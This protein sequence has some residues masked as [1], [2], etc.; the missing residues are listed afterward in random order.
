LVSYASA[1]YWHDYDSQN[2]AIARFTGS[3]GLQSWVGSGI[4]KAEPALLQSGGSQLI[5]FLPFGMAPVNFG[6][7]LPNS[8]F[9]TYSHATGWFH[10]EAWQLVGYNAS[11]LEHNIVEE[12]ISAES[13]STIKGLQ[14]AF[15]RNL[16]LNVNGLATTADVVQE[17]KLEFN[18]TTR[19]ITHE[20]DWYANASTPVSITIPAGARVIGA[21]TDLH[22]GSA[23][24]LRSHVGHAELGDKLWDFFQTTDRPAKVLVPFGRTKVDNWNEGVYLVEQAGSMSFTIVT[25]D[26][27]SSNGGASGGVSVAPP[28]NC[29]QATFKTPLSAATRSIL[30]TATCSGMTRTSSSQIWGCR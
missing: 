30:P 29:N 14:R 12:I 3:I 24:T 11:A 18:G 4:A 2:D 9:T 15:Q 23:S 16:G 19:V 28:S 1:K 5:P 10:P 7:D 6:V 17:Y 8:T 26:G 22:G 21:E 27:N 20:R 25:E 13:A